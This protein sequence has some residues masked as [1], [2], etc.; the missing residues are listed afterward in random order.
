M[1]RKFTSEGNFLHF[2]CIH[3]FEV[4]WRTAHYFI[5]EPD[6]FGRIGKISERKLRKKYYVEWC[7][8]GCY[9]VWIV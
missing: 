1:N 7:L 2:S 8:L 3:P 9:A 4:K 5:N 6:L